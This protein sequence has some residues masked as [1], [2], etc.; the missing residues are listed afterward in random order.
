MKQMLQSKKPSKL[1][2][3]I[4]ADLGSKDVTLQ[5]GNLTKPQTITVLRKVRSEVRIGNQELFG[6]DIA[7]VD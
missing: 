7:V 6:P 3:E 2:R 4:Y 1:R 5:K